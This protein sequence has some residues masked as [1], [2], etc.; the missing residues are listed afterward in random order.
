MSSLIIFFIAAIALLTGAG[1]AFWL[2]RRQ[3]PT[4]GAFGLSTRTIS[5]GKF[6][7]RYHRSG[8]G[9]YLV[10]VHG[11]GADLQ[12]WRHLVPLL[13]KD[14]TVIALDLPGFGRSSKVRG[15]RYGLDD[16]VQRLS[17]FLEALGV[18]AAF[19]AGNS[20]GGNLALWL[21]ILREDRIKGVVVIAPPGH[22]LPM[23]LRRWAWVAK[24]TSYLVSRP[25]LRWLHQRTV[26]RRELVSRERVEETLKTYGR[27]PDAIAS[28]LLATETLAD[29][30]LARRLGE[31]TQPVLMLWGSRDK[32]VTRKMIEGVKAALPRVEMEIH[33]G[34]G[35]HLQEDEPNWVADKIRAFFKT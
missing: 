15:E 28:F 17:G 18:R 33:H 2:W 19:V 34:G 8:R 14:F 22:V 16:Q 29:S 1:V 4:D 9:P 35:H 20:M 5:V 27:N 23:S 13:N 7:I 3:Y 32:L 30:R 31:V 10:L 12:C 24:P 21:A 6:E 26:S 11:I 25:A